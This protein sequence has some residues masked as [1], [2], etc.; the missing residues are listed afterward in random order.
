MFDG[1]Q[2]E[3]TRYKVKNYPV[4]FIV[5]MSTYYCSVFKKMSFQITVIGIISTL[6]KKYLE[7]FSN[8]DLVSIIAK[9]YTK[10][11]ILIQLLLYL[12]AHFLLIYF[13]N[14]LGIFFHLIINKYMTKNV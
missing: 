8:F 14:F 1:Y 4:N 2:L 3:M 7:A 13:F 5:V 11:I 6:L 10:K 9:I 12:L